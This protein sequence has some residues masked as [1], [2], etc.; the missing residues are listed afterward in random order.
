MGLSL[1]VDSAPR[2]EASPQ[3]DPRC[4]QQN[5]S[6]CEVS[7]FQARRWLRAHPEARNGVEVSRLNAQSY[8]HS[9]VTGCHR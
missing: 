7:L 9:T 4:R 8:F 2:V 6:L 5:V 1:L 3:K